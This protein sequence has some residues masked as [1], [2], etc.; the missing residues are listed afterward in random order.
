M[1]ND[2]LGERCADSPS[3][4]R[5]NNSRMGMQA[6]GE[7]SFCWGFQHRLAGCC[8]Q[9]A[10]F[11]AAHSNVPFGR[12]TVRACDPWADAVNGAIRVA[13]GLRGHERHWKYFGVVPVSLKE[14]TSGTWGAG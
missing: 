13:V 10:S 6:L 5:I 12:M 4:Y 1:Q 9:W 2:G 3:K 11:L 8:P 7:R 14:Q